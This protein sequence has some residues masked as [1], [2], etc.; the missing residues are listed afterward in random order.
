MGRFLYTSTQIAKLVG[1]ALGQCWPTLAQRWPNVGPTNFAIWGEFALR[2]I[3]DS[4]GYPPVLLDEGFENLS[5]SERR[6]LGA[7]QDDVRC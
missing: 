7:L 5:Y 2:G 1:P 4:Y 3:F 6:E